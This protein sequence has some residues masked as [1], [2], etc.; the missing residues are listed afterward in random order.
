[1]PYYLAVFYNLNIKKKKKKKKK[2]IQILSFPVT[3][4]F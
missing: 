4:L 3:K 1:M 2:K